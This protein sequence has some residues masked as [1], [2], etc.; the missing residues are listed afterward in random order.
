MV[1]W[2]DA[3]AGPCNIGALG[4]EE[5]EGSATYKGMRIGYSGYAGIDRMVSAPLT[6]RMGHPI[7]V[8]TFMRCARTR[9]SLHLCDR[10]RRRCVDSR[11]CR[12]C[13]LA[14]PLGIGSAWI[15]VAVGEVTSGGR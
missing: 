13:V 14:V 5:G 12:P 15:G 2:C 6:P 8:F 7:A 11:I 4:S 1:A 3:S 9:L 10:L